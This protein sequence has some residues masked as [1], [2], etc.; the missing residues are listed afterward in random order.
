MET[1]LPSLAIKVGICTK[2]G[3]QAQGGRG[4]NVWRWLTCVWWGCEL[5]AHDGVGGGQGPP[6][7]EQTIVN[8]RHTCRET[9]PEA[10]EIIAG[11][12]SQESHL[13]YKNIYL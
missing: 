4:I 11:M 13:K 2:P 1:C 3:S 5:C 12:L 6:R 8:S 7:G 9:L 10:S